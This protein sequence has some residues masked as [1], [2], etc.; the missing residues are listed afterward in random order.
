MVLR[1]TVFCLGV[2]LF[3]PAVALAQPGMQWSTL[4]GGS[5]DDFAEELVLHPDGGLVVAGWTWSVGFPVWPAGSAHGG[6]ED[7]FVARFDDGGVLL[8]SRLFGGPGNDRAYGVDLVTDGSGDVLVAG[9]SDPG[10]PTTPGAYATNVDG[11]FVMRL[12]GSDGATQ[13]STQLPGGRIRSVQADLDGTA[14]VA[15]VASII[16]PATP[17]AFDSTFNGGVNDAFAARLSPDGSALIWATF[18]GGDGDAATDPQVVEGAL[19]SRLSPTGALV[20]VGTADSTGFPVTAGAIQE[21][22]GGGPA[23]GFVSAVAADGSALVWSTF[24]GGSDNEHFWR[25]VLDDTGAVFVGGDC[26]SIDFPVTPGAFDTTQNDG[27]PFLSAGDVVLARLEADGSSLTWAT[28]LGGPLNEHVHGLDLAPDGTVVVGCSSESNGLPATVASFDQDKNGGEDAFLF[29]LSADG[30]TVLYGSYLAGLDRTT[31]H[32]LAVDPEGLVWLAGPT[33]SPDFPTTASAF[34]PTPNGQ[35]DAWVSAMDWSACDGGFS[36]FGQGC[37]S[38]LGSDQVIDGMGCPTPGGTIWMS[39]RHLTPQGST[40]F[41][42]FGL[43]NAT[44]P[45]KPGC[46]LSIGPLTSPLVVLPLPPSGP[47]GAA[48][49]LSTVVP[50]GVPAGTFGVQALFA[51]PAVPLGVSGTPALMVTVGP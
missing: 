7:A 8:W 36:L 48:L 28:Y 1:A 4:L 33:R 34:D 18:L 19:D 20:V 40:L 21:T 45:V 35:W 16:L 23:D 26:R 30:S 43:G 10:F 12:S 38:V 46:S 9:L 31:T 50:P 13:W 51:D 14:L 2:L 29:R 42:F 27:A 22:Y 5:G 37:P 44:V 11:G 47:S 17:G 39:L 25:V 41:L 6:A 3:W 15:G 24:L 49:L 32:A